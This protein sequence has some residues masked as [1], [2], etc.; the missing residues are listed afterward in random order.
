MKKGA[1]MKKTRSVW[2]FGTAQVV[3]GLLASAMQADPGQGIR[4]GPWM[5]SP[6][7]DLA[8]AYS[9]ELSQG[10]TATEEH[11]FLDSEIG[12][13]AAYSAYMIDFSGLG[14][15]GAR[16]YAEHS[17]NNFG[18]GGDV[19]NLKYGLR[20]QLQVQFDQ[21]YRHVED[22][23]QHGSELAVGGIAPDSVLDVSSRDERDIN[24][25]GLSAGRN[26][27]DKIEL[28][29]GYRYDSINYNT[30]SLA[31]LSS[32]VG[33]FEAAYGV[34]DKSAALVTLIG[35]VQ[36]N[37]V[38][39]DNVDY[40]QAR[41]GVKTRGTDK[42]YAKVGAGVQQYD[43]P[44][45]VGSDKTSFNFDAMANWLTTDKISLQAGGRNGTQMSSRYVDNSTDH[46]DFWVS[47]LYQMMPTVLLSA[48]GE[49]RVDAYLDDVPGPDNTLVSRT[50][51]G[52]SIHARADY[53]TPA[54]FMRVYTEATYEKVDSNVSPYDD[55]RVVIGLTLQY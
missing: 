14:F 36:E 25:I 13:K 41:V 54:S 47:A 28:D 17:E 18:E 11:Y 53:L 2:L 46:S 35:G 55:T 1:T 31:D 6:Y 9:T 4:S 29:L 49:Y 30:A 20:D 52:K 33:Q 44:G 26:M 12:F 7:V 51:K 5:V 27:T 43:R 22:L 45:N 3:L 39:D 38:T 24:Q 50:D 19:I 23:D 32:H 37:S 15:G 42:V 40:Y 48:Y 16:N 34:T 21:S 8:G 10:P